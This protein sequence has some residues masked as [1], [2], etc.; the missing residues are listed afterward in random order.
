MY[1]LESKSWRASIW[2]GRASQSD[3]INWVIMAER[4]IFISPR[5][6]LIPL[7]VRQFRHTPGAIVGVWFPGGRNPLAGSGSPSLLCRAPTPWVV[8]GNL[9]STAL[10]C[11]FF[12]IP[13][14]T[15][16]R[17]YPVHL[18]SQRRGL[19]TVSRLCFCSNGHI[20]SIST[21]R[22]TRSL[23]PPNTSNS[24]HSAYCPSYRWI[25]AGDGGATCS[26]ILLDL[27]CWRE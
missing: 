9:Q 20:R 12:L 16:T 4:R 8:A 19:L 11:R 14:H 24:L 10:T 27:A 22:Q 5:Q 17:A 13:Q 6:E 1:D 7:G 23:A 2:T 26:A 25:G 18:S 3:G 21:T 15:P